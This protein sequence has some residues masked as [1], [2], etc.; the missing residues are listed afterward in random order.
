MQSPDAD[1]FK[2]SYGSIIMPTQGAQEP[3]SKTD[4]IEFK[5]FFARVR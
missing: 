5:R 1:F 4:F 2:L 3:A